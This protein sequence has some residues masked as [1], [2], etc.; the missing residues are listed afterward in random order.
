MTDAK[1][2]YLGPATAKVLTY[3][4]PKKPWWKRLP[5]GFMVIVVAPTT[6][7]AIYFLLIASPIYVSEA[8]FIVRATGQ[9]QPSAIGVA[10]QGVGL[11]T[12]ATDAYVVHEFID[13]RD[14]LREL[15]QKMDVASMIGPKGTDPLAKYPRLGESR[16][17]EGLYRGLRR[18]VTVGYDATN[19][20]ST[21]RVKAFSARDAQAMNLAMLESGERLI[22]RLNAR[23]AGNA[24]SEAELSRNLAQAKLAS[25]QQQLTAFRNREQFISPQLSATEGAQLI[26]GLLSTVANL[27]AERAQLSSEAPNSPQLPVLDSRIRAYEGQIAAEREKMAGSSTS[28]APKIGAYEDLMSNRELAEKEL[29]QATAALVGAEQEARRQKLYLER[30]VN[31]NLPDAPSEPKRWLAILTVFA[32]ALLAY[33]VG[34]LIWAGVHEHR[35]V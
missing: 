35:Q 12:G 32:S 29:G 33:G 18:F 25:A 31:P 3:D 17:E 8:R 10:L 1:L 16:S 7:A 15:S 11:S 27:R 28:L 4:K 2:N 14:G 30:V 13:S 24:V 5:V 19:G 23:A 34:W 26:G 9:T 20:I 22:N 21:L 6:I